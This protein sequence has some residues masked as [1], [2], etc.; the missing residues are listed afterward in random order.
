MSRSSVKAA[1]K[2]FLSTIPGVKSVFT[3]R[4][5]RIDQREM[6]AIVIEISDADTKVKSMPA[7]GGKREKTYKAKATLTRIATER[8]PIAAGVEWD[9]LLDSIELA[10]MKRPD[11][12]GSAFLAG[13]GYIRTSSSE[14]RLLGAE[15]GNTLRLAVIE[16]DIVE[17]VTVVT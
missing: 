8:D 17:Y 6:P 11:L 9:D 7:I 3:D 2:A 16:F 12:D 15:D 14:P 5:K 1:A 13:V 10:I 4:P